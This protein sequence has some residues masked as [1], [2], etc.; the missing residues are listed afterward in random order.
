MASFL[1]VAEKHCKNGIKTIRSDNA[2]EFC[3]HNMKNLFEKHGTIHQFTDP[4]TPEQ[5]G[6]TK[7][8]DKIEPS[9]NQYVL[10][11]MKVA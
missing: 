2:L 7:W 1:K 5:N 10:S 6:V 3:S 8:K 9:W 4:Y 11:W